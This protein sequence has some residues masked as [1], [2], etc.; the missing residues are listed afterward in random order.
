MEWGREESR[1]ESKMP[2]FVLEETV[3]ERP[4]ITQETAEVDGHR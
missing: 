4:S 1:I 2:S 3:A